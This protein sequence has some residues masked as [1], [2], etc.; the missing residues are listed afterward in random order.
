MTAGV[1]LAAG[2]EAQKQELLPAIAKGE[3]IGTVAWLEPKNGFGPKGVQ[4]R[5]ASSA[6]ASC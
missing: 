5:A 6:R 1:V 3:A 2:S 4:A